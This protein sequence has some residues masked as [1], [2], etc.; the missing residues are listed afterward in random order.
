MQNN[1]LTISVYHGGGGGGRRVQE[2]GIGYDTTIANKGTVQD[3]YAELVADIKPM[4]G[5][6]N[7]IIR[8]IT[9]PQ[10]MP[11]SLLAELKQL[12]GT[13]P[14]V[15]GP[16]VKLMADGKEKQLFTETITL[17]GGPT[18]ATLNF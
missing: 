15:A 4:L 2:I 3:A 6:R 11:D 1:S 9:Y 13:I 17:E 16:S 14:L 18:I 8:N 7:V 12:A 5:N 10:N